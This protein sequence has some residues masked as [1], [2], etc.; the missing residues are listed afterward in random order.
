MET[1]ER[2]LN[3]TIESYVEDLKEINTALWVAV[4]TMGLFII[5]ICNLPTDTRKQDAIIVSQH[6]RIQVL[7]KQI[8]TMNDSLE[9]E[10]IKLTRDA[11][12]KP[13]K[14]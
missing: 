7:E 2:I 11:N 6:A 13:A 4:V 12:F 5:V 14:K 3:G 9:F 10:Y 1:K 8:K